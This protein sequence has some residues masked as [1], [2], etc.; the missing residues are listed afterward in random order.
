MFKKNDEE[1]IFIFGKPFL[2][3]Y[4]IIF[5]PDRK[6]IGVYTKK[7]INILNVTLWV[8]IVFLAI[9]IISLIILIIKRNKNKPRK[10]RANELDEEFIYKDISKED[11]KL[12][13]N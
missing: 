11:D 8:I 9:I 4:Q 13:I 7:T 5:E 6:L 1:E 2:K 12:G 10:I 3:K